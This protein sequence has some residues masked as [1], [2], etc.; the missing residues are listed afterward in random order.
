M[1]E[2]QTTGRRREVG[3]ALKRIRQ[4]R[5]WPAYKLAEHLDW[6]PSHISRSEAGKR[7]V[8][9]VDAGFYMGMCGVTN[10]ELQEV[11]KV[12]N[13]P[14]DYRL[15]LHEGRIPDELRTLIFLES[16]ATQIHS[17]Q[18]VY[19]PGVLQTANYA[20]ALFLANGRIEPD[21][22]DYLVKVRKARSGI[23]DTPKPPRCML[24]VH[25]HALRSPVGGPHV[26]NEQLMHLLFMGDRSECAIRVV[27]MSAGAPG[28]VCCSFQIFGYKDD[29][30]LVCLQNVTTSEF[31]E[32]DDEVATYQ[33]ILNRVASVALDGAQSREW[34]ATAASTFERQG[35]TQ[36]G[37]GGL[38]EE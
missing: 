31:L 28:M 10:G 8:T 7:R 34:L 2:L 24:Y 38:A 37:T 15:Q 3:A 5:G 32:N 27:P 11:L 19:I 16:T 23:L 6:T 21:R 20:R 9:D 30:P 26:M 18:P 36:G 4:E 17:F 22:I 35:D 25:E 29:P 33:D 13:E 14:D 12:V 1:S